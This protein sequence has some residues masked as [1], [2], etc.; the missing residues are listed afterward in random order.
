[1]YRVIIVIFLRE[2]DKQYLRYLILD[3]GHRNLTPVVE[4]TG[5]SRKQIHDRLKLIGL[6]MKKL[7]T[8]NITQHFRLCKLWGFNSQEVYTY[9][10][11]NKKTACDG[12][13]DNIPSDG[14]AFTIKGFHFEQ[15]LN[16]H[17]TEYMTEEFLRNA[18]KYG[19]GGANLTQMGVYSLEDGLFRRG[20]ARSKE[21]IIDFLDYK[22]MDK[23]ILD[24]LEYNDTLDLPYKISQGAGREF[25]AKEEQYCSSYT[26]SDIRKQFRR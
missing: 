9:V 12:A 18:V 2:E 19:F 5:F 26:E 17:R 11:H 16:R 23:D 7:R 1:M 15:G 21:D 10:T 4:L 20:H 8:D 14:S 3:L 13:G 6:N 22:G 24:R 25:Q